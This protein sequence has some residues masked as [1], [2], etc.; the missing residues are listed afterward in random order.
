MAMSKLDVRG[1]VPPH[2]FLNQVNN[3]VAVVKTC[4]FVV[5]SYP[6]VHQLPHI[7]LTGRLEL[8]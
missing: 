4:H 8:N 7:A 3:T 2:Y 5:S 6:T 1:Y